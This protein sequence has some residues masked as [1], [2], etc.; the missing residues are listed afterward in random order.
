MKNYESI[1]V[2]GDFNSNIATTDEGNMKFLI[3]E[4][5]LTHSATISELQQP[6]YV[7]ALTATRIDHMLHKGALTPLRCQC[8]DHYAYLNDHK[9]IVTRYYTH[10]NCVSHNSTLLPVKPPR[11]DYT[12]TLARTQLQTALQSQSSHL[13]LPPEQRLQQIQTDTI[14]AVCTLSANKPHRRVSTISYFWCPTNM[15]LEIHL[16]HVCAIVRAIYG[17]NNGW[18]ATEKNYLPQIVHIRKQW[19]RN[20]RQLVAS[21]I[22]TSLPLNHT[23]MKIT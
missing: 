19:K 20:I 10:R 1:I 5:Q 11:F 18:R 15:A 22:T 9:P 7:R 8:L 17:H 13:Q 23:L 4:L 21:H 6:S 12:Q 2:G 16:S 3:T 14:A